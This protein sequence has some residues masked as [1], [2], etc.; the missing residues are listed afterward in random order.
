MEVAKMQS[1]KKFTTVEDSNVHCKSF[2]GIVNIDTL[3]RNKQCC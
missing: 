2:E 3:K 1:K